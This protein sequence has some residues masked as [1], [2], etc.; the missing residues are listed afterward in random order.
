MYINRVFNYF[1]LK[2]FLAMPEEINLIEEWKFYIYSQ[3]KTETLSN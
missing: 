2:Y 3:N 1:A